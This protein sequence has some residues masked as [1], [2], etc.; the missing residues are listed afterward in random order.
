MKVIYAGNSRTAFEIEIGR[1][2]ARGLSYL[3]AEGLYYTH[4]RPLGHRLYVVYHQQP[5]SFASRGTTGGLSHL[6]CLHRL[7]RAADTSPL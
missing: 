7:Y 4:G 2:L 5:P 1:F 3:Q 6:V